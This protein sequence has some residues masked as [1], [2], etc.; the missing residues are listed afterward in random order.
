MD[1]LQQQ[2]SAMLA[3]RA[4]S[5]FTSAFMKRRNTGS[6]GE[7]HEGGDGDSPPKREQTRSGKAAGVV[8]AL[9]SGVVD[10]DGSG[11][12]GDAARGAGAGGGVAPRDCPRGGRKVLFGGVVNAAASSASPGQTDDLAA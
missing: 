10:S 4:A 6:Q 7:D 5:K 1:K 12:A 2:R 3:T 9:L 11:A 8:A